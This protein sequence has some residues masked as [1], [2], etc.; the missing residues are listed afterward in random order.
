MRGTLAQ[1]ASVFKHQVFTLQ[2]CDLTALLLP[3]F[4]LYSLLGRCGVAFLGFAYNIEDNP[5]S[6]APLSG[7]IGAMGGMVP[8]SKL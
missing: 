4:L 8:V 3:L 5:Y 7:L 1:Y 6:H 2:Q